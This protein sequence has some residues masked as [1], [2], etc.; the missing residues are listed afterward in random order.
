[1]GR[2]R[3]VK[4]QAV[5]NAH[6]LF[7][8]LQGAL[9]PGH[10]PALGRLVQDLAVLHGEIAP[11]P[12]LPDAAGGNEALIGV[13]IHVGHAVVRPDDV[14][15]AGVVDHDVGVGTGPQMALSGEQAV[16]LGRVLTEGQTAGR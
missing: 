14:A 8:A 9:P 4:K 2:I 5:R 13:I 15:G 3:T 6:S 7:F 12:H 16:Q 11:E 10:V 1:M